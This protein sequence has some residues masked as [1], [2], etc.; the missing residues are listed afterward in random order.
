MKNTIKSAISVLLATVIAVSV[1]CMAYADGEQAELTAAEPSDQY[2]ELLSSDKIGFYCNTATGEIS[3]TDKKTGLV[4][5][6]NPNGAADNEALKGTARTAAQSQLI[7]TLSDKQGNQTVINSL[8]ES[9]NRDG[10]TVFKNKDLVKLTYKFPNYG[11][12]IPVVYRIDGERFISEIPVGEIVSEDKGLYLSRIALLPYFGAAEKN[13]DGWILVPDGCGAIIPF[14]SAKSPMYEQRLFGAD[15]GK[16]IK[17]LNVSEQPALLPATVLFYENR[18]GTGAGLIK[19]AEQGAALADI[20]ASAETTD[21]CYNISYF[22]FTYRESDNVTLMDQT[23]KATD[24][25][26]FENQPAKAEKFSV[27]YTFADSNNATLTGFAEKV[28]ERVYDGFDIPKASGELPVYI[29]SYMGVRKTK[30]FL[31][32]PYNGFQKLTDIDDCRKI[33]DDFGLQSVVMSLIGID[34][35]GASGGRIDGKLNVTGAVG[36]VKKLRELTEYAEK[37]G[38]AVYLSAEFTEYTKGNKNNR[39]LSVSNQAIVSHFYDYGSKEI[40]SEYDGL[41][42]LKCNYILKNVTSWINSAKKQGILYC[43]P[44]TLSSSPY[45]SGNGM[46]RNFT[47]NEF[48]KA[49]E[50]FR[51]NGV[52]LLLSQASAYAVPYASGIKS[53]PISSSGFSACGTEVPFIQLVLHGVV[54]YSVPPVNLSGNTDYIFLKAI[55]TGSALSFSFIA[56]DYTVLKETPLDSLNG[57]EYSLWR[58]TALSLTEKLSDIMAGTS[59]AHITDYKIISDN[60]R[61]VA[62]ENGSAFLL[63][64][65]ETEYNYGG[66]TVEPMSYRRTEGEIKQ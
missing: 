47:V 3:V 7:L 29:N 21:Q 40:K 30:Y 56:E 19:Y 50:L 8:V 38:S 48:C 28:R 49:L 20:C 52:S 13:E 10:L 27:S 58:G 54:S 63:N 6:S 26:I 42:M 64:Y 31:G 36:S 34:R 39:V 65:G 2:E 46:D 35:D 53:V 59:S 4:Y 23:S 44:G 33:L 51:K 45:R 15:R 43:N 66:I 11:I 1:N 24:V 5:T 9:V 12:E 57:S 18:G 61:Y 22:S 25:V 17:T 55:E 14:H 62:Y 41:Y 32:I 37:G 16:Q 60:V